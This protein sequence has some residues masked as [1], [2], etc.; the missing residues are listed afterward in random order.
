MISEILEKCGLAKSE[1]NKISSR[2][3]TEQLFKKINIKDN[4]QRLT[5][6]RA[7]DKIDRLDWNEAKKN[8]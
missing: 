4:Q 1:Y 3:I 5:A 7:L 8:Y 6:L 2:E